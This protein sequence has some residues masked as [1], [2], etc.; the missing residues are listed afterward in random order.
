MG[1]QPLIYVLI[2]GFLYGSVTVATRFCLGQ[3]DPITYSGLRLALGALVYVSLYIFRVRGRKW[4]KDR[5]FWKRAFIY[6]IIGDAVP[7]LLFISA[8]QYLSSGV[9]G[10]LVTFYPVVTVIMGHFYLDDE[11]INKLKFIGILLSTSG[12]LLM[13]VFGETGLADPDGT[14]IYGYLM[15]L[16]SAIVGSA[17]S[18]YARKLLVGY[19]TIDTVSIRMISSALVTI[20]LAIIFEGLDISQ[21]TL[22]GFIVFLYST[23][24]IA[25]SF[26]LGFYVLKKYGVTVSAMSGYLP[27][28]ITTVGGMLLL[29]EQ[30]T[31]V[32]VFGMILILAG[33]TVINQNLG[34][35]SL[36]KLDLREP[37]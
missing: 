2:L 7:I 33:V 31:L 12:A 11:R 26:F 29:N 17:S 28:I 4:P 30:I 35:I 18:I 16:G 10:I 21:V 24:V 23:F 13:A 15:I 20:P 14:A 6:G 8:M 22:S 25:A 27:P 9:G 37:T 5:V 1:L 34:K 32:M 19:D 3:F 36:G